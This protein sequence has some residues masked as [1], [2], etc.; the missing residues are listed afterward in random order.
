VGILGIPM[1]TSELWPRVYSEE[2]TG[3]GSIIRA[4]A[5]MRVSFAGGGTDFPHWY[6]EHGGAVLCTTINHYARVTLYP[7]EDQAVRIRSVDL[8]Y[9]TNYHIEDEPA[10]DGVL[11]LAKA[12]IRRLGGRRG[13]D[14]DIRSDA[15]AGSGLGGSSALTAAVIGA[16]A[17]YQSATLSNYELA[18]MNYV[19][20]R[21]D[22]Q[23]VGGMQDQ[24]ATTFGGFNVIE[25]STSDVLVNPLRIDPA[26]LNDLEAHLML[27]STGSVRLHHG[28]VHNQIRYYEENP[29]GKAQCMQRIY[30]LVFE[31][32]DAL[33]KGR[34]NEF[35]AMLHEGFV[36]KKQ[37]N[38]DLTEGT[39]AD[40]LYEEAR[41]HGAI[42]GKLMGAGGGGYLLLYCETH[43]QHEVRRA[44][45]AVGGRFVGFSIEPGGLQ[46]W[47][48]R[49]L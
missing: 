11:D 19:V 24:Y 3:V 21:S 20:E 47:R 48:T 6:N 28:L 43:C 15:P 38:P 7:R 41:R 13:M 4:K 35:G 1:P 12:A 44:L 25:F 22:V 8:G 23:I 34:L 36:A 2:T 9:V 10:Y 40:L 46:A 5:P 27:C 37:M 29:A 32:K 26:I 39:N 49:C 45:E 18:A 14:L 33:L 16:V 30:D 31:M 17:A 42:G